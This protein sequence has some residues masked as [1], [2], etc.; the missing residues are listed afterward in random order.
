MQVLQED[1]T[2]PVN[3]MRRVTAS[4]FWPL[5]MN[6]IGAIRQL[7]EKQ[8]APRHFN[9]ICMPN[10]EV[11]HSVMAGL[12][13]MPVLLRFPVRRKKHT[14]VQLR[15]EVVLYLQK[16]CAVMDVGRK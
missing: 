2:I 1:T 11:M 5:A 4:A 16:I 14:T 15:I 3:W 13:C 9:S 8:V 10:V 6:M 7:R 12:M